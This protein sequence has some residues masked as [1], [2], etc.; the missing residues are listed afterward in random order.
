MAHGR[1][2]LSPSPRWMNST[3]NRFHTNTNTNITNTRARRTYIYVGVYRQRNVVR[4]GKWA[5]V[6]TD[7][8]DLFMRKKVIHIA[9]FICRCQRSIYLSAFVRNFNCQNAQN[10]V[11]NVIACINSIIFSLC[12]LIFH[13]ARQRCE[14]L[15]SYVVAASRALEK[16]ENKTETKAQ[17]K[18]NIVSY[19]CFERVWWPTEINSPNI[20]IAIT[21][22]VTAAAAAV[23]I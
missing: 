18:G 11:F 10:Y 9:W 19:F 8:V 22:V 1:W 12:E 2:F 3:W 7:S 15:M 20:W 5:L 17:Q 4:F 21:R 6:S 13:S 14:W 16:K 23:Y